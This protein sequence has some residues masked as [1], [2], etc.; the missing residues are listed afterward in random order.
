M[1]PKDEIQRTIEEV[2]RQ[3]VGISHS[4]YDEPFGIVLTDRAEELEKALHEINEFNRL[5]GEAPNTD[6]A[7]EVL[8]SVMKELFEAA[9]ETLDFAREENDTLVAEV[10]RG[11]YNA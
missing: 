1:Y 8:R 4:V 9:I 3:T 6:K 5:E 2:A 10:L 7:H 11:D